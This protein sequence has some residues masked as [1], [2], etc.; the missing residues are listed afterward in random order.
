MA[1]NQLSFEVLVA[2]SSVREQQRIAYQLLLELK[3]P[4]VVLAETALF[5]NPI[6]KTITIGDRPYR[7]VEKD[8]RVAVLSVACQDAVHHLGWAAAAKAYKALT[9][10]VN[11]IVYEADN[12]I[13]IHPRDVWCPLRSDETEMVRH[14][15]EF[16][17]GRLVYVC[18]RCG[19]FPIR[20]Y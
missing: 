8:G 9:S 19:Y 4:V 12:T 17:A 16:E 5:E 3:T 6:H 20:N 18:Q 7:Y 15:M 11:D 14:D 13:L 2:R 1:A 10:R